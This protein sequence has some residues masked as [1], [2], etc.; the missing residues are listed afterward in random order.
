M[1]KKFLITIILLTTLTLSNAYANDEVS[2]LAQNW[3][4]TFSK[5]I[6]SKYTTWS[7]ITYFEWFSDKL[8]DLLAQKSFNTNQINLINDLIKLSNEYLFNIDINEKEKSNKLILNSNDLL[9]DFKHFS[10]NSEHIFLENWIW[11]TYNFDTHLKF[12]D[13]AV[14]KKEDLVY[15]WINPESSIVYLDEN[16][17]LWF[18]VKY[19]KI[20]LISDTIIYW[21][22]DKF[23]F[24][25]EIKNDKKVLNYETD[26]LFKKL[27]E[28]TLKITSWKIK[29][30]KIKSIYNYILNNTEYPKT[31]SLDD[32]K[33]FSWID[34]FKNKGWVCE[35]YTKEF[36]YMLN[37]ANI[38]NVE[39]VRWFVLDASDFPKI[40]H[41]WVRIWDKYYDPTFDDP[42]WATETKSFEKY[43]Y[44]DLPKDLFYTNR[45]DFDKIPEYLKTTDLS[46]RKNLI[47]NNIVPLVPKYKDSWFN[48]LKLY[49]FKSD[50][51]IALNK[52]IN[53]DDLKNITKYYE[54]NWVEIIINWAKKTVTNLQYYLV[55][56]EQIDDILEQ[57]NYN[58]NWYYL[59]KWKLSNWTYEYRLWYDV[60]IE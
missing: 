16:N 15:N 38:K 12:P 19:T 59:F 24:L 2:V 55:D 51:W 31:F 46:F 11:Y 47:I 28:D 42:V 10:Y 32:S 23:N 13:W 49:L 3:F 54:T 52:I 39:V 43:K 30:I 36:L 6:H 20:K 21:I 7:E 29:D 57:L 17:S 1:V 60:V 50:N 41:A 27:K 58:L 34:T 5:K 8:S 48:I 56:E 14:I 9:K 35:W 40:G 44:Y 4:T 26:E 33:L 25:K 22:P 18:V 37:F 45:Y 53:I